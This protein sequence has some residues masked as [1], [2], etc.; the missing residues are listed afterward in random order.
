[1]ANEIIKKLKELHQRFDKI[2]VETRFIPR[3]SEC[4][5]DLEFFIKDL[6]KE[7]EKQPKLFN[8]KFEAEDFNYD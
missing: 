3:M 6:E 2:E 1:M 8:I 4:L 7:F 5:V